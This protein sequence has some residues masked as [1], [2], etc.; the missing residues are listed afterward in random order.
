MTN[1]NI[2]QHLFCANVLLNEGLG[3]T[4]VCFGSDLMMSWW[5]T[6]RCF[7]LTNIAM[8]HCSY[9]IFLPTLSSSLAAVVCN[10][11]QTTVSGATSLSHMF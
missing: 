4:G 5:N 3:T 1:N 6:I 7:M 8:D 2:W 11:K 9:H 10:I